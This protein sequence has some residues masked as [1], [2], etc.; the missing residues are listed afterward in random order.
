MRAKKTLPGG[1][2]DSWEVALRVLSVLGH[3]TSVFGMGTGVGAPL[4]RPGSVCVC[5]VGGAL[6]TGQDGVGV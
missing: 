1:G 2:L 4:E 3:F 6:Q 5:G